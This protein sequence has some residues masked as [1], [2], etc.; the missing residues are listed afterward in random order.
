MHY[1][2]ENTA[3]L[4]LTN[5]NSGLATQSQPPFPGMGNP[6]RGRRSLAH[7]DRSH[8]KAGQHFTTKNAPIK[9]K[10]IA[11]DSELWLDGFWKDGTI[12]QTLTTYLICRT[13]HPAP[14]SL[15]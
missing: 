6:H 3:G 12:Y 5:A 1:T 13:C 4:T 15:L 14:A 9:L 10:H 8:V 11:D 2:P 7:C